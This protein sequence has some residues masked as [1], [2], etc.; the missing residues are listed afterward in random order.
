MVLNEKTKS[1]NTN[2][3][4]IITH[5]TWSK[6]SIPSSMMNNFIKAGTEQ[7]DTIKSRT[8]KAYISVSPARIER[9]PLHRITKN[10]IIDTT[11][12]IAHGNVMYLYTSKQIS[13]S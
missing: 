5:E 10:T 8:H 13:M 4:T 11:A 3:Q 2:K 12:K 9:S 7:T 1:C 6:Y